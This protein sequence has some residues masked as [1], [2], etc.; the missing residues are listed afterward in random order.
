MKYGVQK[1]ERSDIRLTLHPAL[2][3]SF[4]SMSPLSANR[5]LI[6]VMLISVAASCRLFGD[7]HARAS[8]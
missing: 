8:T 4:L 6:Q 5:H 2:N 7:F 3:P 1:D